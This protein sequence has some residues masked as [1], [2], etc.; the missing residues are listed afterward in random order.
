VESGA[1]ARAADSFSTATA[2]ATASLFRPIVTG[3]AAA[4]R[5]TAP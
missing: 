3:R 1:Y 4:P 5:P 2:D